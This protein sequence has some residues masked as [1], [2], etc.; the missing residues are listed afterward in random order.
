M[1]ASR[2]A[3][4]A[5]VGLTVG[6][7]SATPSAF[8]DP[9]AAP[10]EAAAPEVAP[11]EPGAAAPTTAEPAGA[12]PPPAPSG[13]RTAKGIQIGGRPIETITAADVVRVL[14]A[15]GYEVRTGTPQPC[16]NVEQLNFSVGNDAVNA[17]VAVFRIIEPAPDDNCSP[18]PV[19]G[20]VKAW[21]DATEGDR[22]TTVM[23]YDE[24][25]PSLVVVNAMGKGGQPE[26]HKVIDAL[27]ASPGTK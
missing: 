2:F 10:P 22:P 24:A 17:L 23:V 18:T 7:G 8:P 3:P 9:A 16:G 26:A 13:I 12:K 5:I 1:L 15:A 25:A 11:A 6:C 20:Y 21:R 4:L 27:L 19:S 14:S